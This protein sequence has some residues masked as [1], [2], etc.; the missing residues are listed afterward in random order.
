VDAI[1]YIGNWF[2]Q[3]ILVVLL[4]VFLDF[5]LP[6]QTMQKYARLVMGMVLVSMML[7]PIGNV[8]HMNWN[9]VEEQV[10]QLLQQNSSQD[11]LSDI[12]RKA[13]EIQNA[14][15]SQT[16]EQWKQ[17]VEEVVKQQIE[18]QFDVN[19]T[20]MDVAITS[21]QNQD[22]PVVQSIQLT[23]EDVAGSDSSRQI[24]QGQP[25]DTVSAIQI[26]PVKPVEKVA[27]Q[28]ADTLQVQ[29]K[30]ATDQTLTKTEQTKSEQIAAFLQDQFHLSKD[31]IHIAFANTTRR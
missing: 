14:E 30:T 13:R 16:I 5:L 12:Y 2:K 10:L 26:A 21:K 28:D 19:V 8:L 23:L 15:Q 11:S 18:S 27:Q 22:T 29:G 24:G 4:A 20:A 9:Q 7:V 6:S 17:R 31:A 3:I 1:Q 25:G